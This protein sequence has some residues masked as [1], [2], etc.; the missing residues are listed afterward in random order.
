[1][2]FQH[3]VGQAEMAIRD[4]PRFLGKMI[5][6]KGHTGGGHLSATSREGNQ[7]FIRSKMTDIIRWMNAAMYRVD[8]VEQAFAQGGAICATPAALLRIDLHIGE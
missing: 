7:K 4:K 6:R 1:M 5:L 2:Q 8:G 3:Y